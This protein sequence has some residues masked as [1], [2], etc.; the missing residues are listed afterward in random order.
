MHLF[1]EVILHLILMVKFPNVF[2]SLVKQL[3]LQEL[4]Q[5][6]ILMLLL[7]LLEM[8]IS[9]I[10]GLITTII[11]DVGVRRIFKVATKMEIHLDQEEGA[12]VVLQLLMC[13]FFQFLPFWLLVNFISPS[14][15][16]D[17]FNIFFCSYSFF[18]LFSW[19]SFTPSLP[20]FIFDDLGFVFLFLCHLL[21]DCEQP[22]IIDARR[23]FIQDVHNAVIKQFVIRLMSRLVVTRSLSV[24]FYMNDPS[25]EEDYV[26]SER[27]CL[28]L[29]GR[30]KVE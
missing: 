26:I 1:N 24:Q 27:T 15:I 5:L 10:Y 22:Q 9:W 3:L 30:W 4:P 25:N 11:E 18:S 6:P 21:M 20:F 28:F 19:L 8:L 7:I 16:W 29:S 23:K 13:E 14:M 12:V 2:A 17:L